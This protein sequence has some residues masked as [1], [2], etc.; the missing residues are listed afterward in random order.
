[1]QKITSGFVYS[2]AASSAFSIAWC[3]G[4]RRVS[5]IFR[6]SPGGRGGRSPPLPPR[7]QHSW[8]WWGEVWRCSHCLLGS[9]SVT[10]PLPSACSGSCKLDVEVMEA[11]HHSMVAF[12]CSDGALLGICRKC[13]FWTTGARVSG[14][15]KPCTGFATP[16][17]QAAWRLVLAG[18]YPRCRKSHVTVDS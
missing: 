15:A 3:R 13:R 16:A 7:L 1:M 4:F 6:P 17:P 10:K 9:R 2:K 18:K 14:L 11:L 8:S 12:Q 5:L